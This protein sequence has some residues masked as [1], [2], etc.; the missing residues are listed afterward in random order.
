MS[1]TR[2]RVTDYPGEVYLSLQKILRLIDLGRSL[3]GRAPSLT[4]TQMRVL[5]LFYEYETLHTTE[6]SRLLGMSVASAHNVLSRLE[7]AGYIRRTKNLENK[8]FTDVNLTAMGQ[9][10]INEFRRI[11]IDGLESLLSPLG[12]A[13]LKRLLSA[14]KEAGQLLEQAMNS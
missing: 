7:T 3:K 12:D 13:E 10:S 6:V 2:K 9:K 8:R 14:L 5:S 11:Q 1:S 4:H